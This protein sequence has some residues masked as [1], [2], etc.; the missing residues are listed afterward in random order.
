MTCQKIKEKKKNGNL[1]PIKYF[2]DLDRAQKVI[3]V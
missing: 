3:V 2:Y 1:R